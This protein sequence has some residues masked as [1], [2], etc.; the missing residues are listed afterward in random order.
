ALVCALAL[1]AF[2]LWGI[3]FSRAPRHITRQIEHRYDVA[4]PAFVRS[5]GVLL[6][7]PLAQGNRAQT[8]V[9]GDEIFP[10][11]LD[12]IRSAKRSITLESYIYWSGDVGRRFSAALAERARNG[13]KVHV[14]LD[15][16][17]SKKMDEKDTDAMGAAGVQVLKFHH[18]EWYRY[19]HLNHRTHRKILVVDGVVG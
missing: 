18:P 1:I 13:V 7:P 3:V 17:G 16:M 6:G 5:M 2:T 14:L 11:M 12:A 8:L 10:A 9:N 4:E 15:W 19:T